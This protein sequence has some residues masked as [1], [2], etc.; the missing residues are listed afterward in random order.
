MQQ[1][2]P[3]NALPPQQGEY[4]P[5]SQQMLKQ[6]LN[7]IDS[8]DAIDRQEQVTHFN[9]Q[10]MDVPQDA[11]SIP[12]PSLPKHLRDDDEDSIDDDD[13]E[14]QTF[15]DMIWKEARDPLLFTSVF[16]SLN[17]PFMVYV[18]SKYMPW[19]INRHNGAATYIGLII[20]GLIGGIL[21][22]LVKYFIY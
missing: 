10:S 5:M 14:E 1:S 2:T 22:Y 7:E 11:P 3:I 19:M 13:E 17:L 16:I 21:F 15:T 12:L 6:I 20:R 4:D 18:L 8:T 9:D